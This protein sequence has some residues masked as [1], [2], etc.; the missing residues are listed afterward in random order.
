MLILDEHTKWNTPYFSIYRL[1][2]CHLRQCFDSLPFIFRRHLNQQIK[3]LVDIDIHQKGLNWVVVTFHRGAIRISESTS[4]WFRSAL[5]GGA[6]KLSIVLLQNEPQ[7]VRHQWVQ[8]KSWNDIDRHVVSAANQTSG[9]G[10]L[11]IVRCHTGPPHGCVNFSALQI[12]QI[13]YVTSVVDF[14]QDYPFLSVI[15]S[16]SCSSRRGFQTR[17]GP[18]HSRKRAQSQLDQSKQCPDA[19]RS[20]GFVHL[21]DYPRKPTLGRSRRTCRCRVFPWS[22]RPNFPGWRIFSDKRHF[23]TQNVFV[24]DGSW[25]GKVD[26]HVA[27]R[28]C[29][30]NEWHC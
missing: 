11:N 2:W 20:F 7:W 13:L 6:S 30:F 25:H 3:V 12:V 26:C 15:C 21:R 28:P 27:A 18:D 9:L 22:Y 29:E 4:W 1:S 24:E 8:M 5:F 14:N 17:P 19:S 16:D 10:F 23:Q